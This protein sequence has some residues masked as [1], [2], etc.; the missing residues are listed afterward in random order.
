MYCRK[1]I[2][3][4][5]LTRTQPENKLA[6]IPFHA[7]NL[8]RPIGQYVICLGLLVALLTR[9]LNLEFDWS[10]SLFKTTSMFGV[11]GLMSATCIILI[12]HIGKIGPADVSSSMPGKEILFKGIFL[13]VFCHNLFVI[14]TVYYDWTYQLSPP[15]QVLQLFPTI[16]CNLHSYFQIHYL[17]RPRHEQSD[18]VLF[19]RM[20]FLYNLIMLIHVWQFRTEYYIS[21]SFETI[22]STLTFIKAIL[23]ILVLAY[24]LAALY[25]FL[26]LPNKV[27]LLWP[28]FIKTDSFTTAEPEISFRHGGD[29][30]ISIAILTKQFRPLTIPSCPIFL[31]PNPVDWQQA[32]LTRTR[33][34]IIDGYDIDV[35]ECPDNGDELVVPKEPPLSVIPATE[36]VC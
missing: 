24:R 10:V 5:A 11:W 21:D 4:T 2:H 8:A 31:F 15:V 29:L 28:S 26:E 27:V 9:T 6:M 12:N 19:K 32:T 18:N 34:A 25:C 1:K 14:A 23:M 20:S 17:L 7:L 16:Y 36:L 3:R 35:Q 13:G 33:T 22:A 30:V